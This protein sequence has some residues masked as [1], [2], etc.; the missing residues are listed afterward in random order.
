[1]DVSLWELHGRGECS[2]SPLLMS[3]LSRSSCVTEVYPAGC[4]H[5]W[6]ILS[7]SINWD[8]SPT[9]H[10]YAHTSPRLQT[11]LHN[12]T[13]I[14]GLREVYT[15]PPIL[16]FFPLYLATYVYFHPHTQKHTLSFS[17]LAICLTSLFRHTHIADCCV[18]HWAPNLP[19]SVSYQVFLPHDSDWRECTVHRHSQSWLSE[20][21]QLPP[22]VLEEKCLCLG[23]CRAIN[24]S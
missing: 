6:R 19:L 7:L 13:R 11:Q 21:T 5:V 17:S 18:I 12:G 16:S 22:V 9:T 10:I 4:L 24:F 23:Y 2:T 8:L 3:P 14:S 15:P 20:R 1:M